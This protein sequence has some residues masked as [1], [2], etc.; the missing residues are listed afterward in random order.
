MCSVPVTF[1]GGS[2]MQYGGAPGFQLGLKS[3]RDSHIG[4][5]FS[6]IACGSKLLASS[7]MKSLGELQE[8]TRRVEIIADDQRLKF[9]P[10]QHPAHPPPFGPAAEPHPNFLRYHLSV[11]GATLDTFP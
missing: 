4:Y 9:P 10:L 2:W 1:G 3:P 7:D 5:H 6:S 11:I 8:M